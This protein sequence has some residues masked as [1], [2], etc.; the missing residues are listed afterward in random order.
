M[1]RLTS[2]RRVLEEEYMYET[3]DRISGSHIR[4][5]TL[6]EVCVLD[7]TLEMSIDKEWLEFRCQKSL[8]SIRSTYL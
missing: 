4:L 3:D 2:I 6:I 8:G 5:S 7:D 1:S